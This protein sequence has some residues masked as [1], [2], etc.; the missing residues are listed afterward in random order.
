MTSVT[1]LTL[2]FALL[3]ACDG[4]LLRNNLNTELR[5]THM[6]KRRTTTTTTTVQLQRTAVTKE[7]KRR[8]LH[9]VRQRHL[10]LH[11]LI[12]TN[13]GHLPEA[14]LHKIS[15]TGKRL[16]SFYGVV[17]IGE[18]T[19]HHHHHD[20]SYKLLFDTGSSELWVT[21][22]N[23]TAEYEERCA[24]HN[25]YGEKRSPSLREGRHG[26]GF[27]K[28]HA[29]LEIDYVSG[30]IEG[31]L[32]RDA[33]TIGGMRVLQQL[34]GVADVVDVALL[35]DVVWDG[36]LGLGFPDASVPGK[37]FFDNALDQGLLNRPMFG[38][39]LGEDG[40]RLTLGGVHAENVPVEYARQCQGFHGPEW[41][42]EILDIEI[43]HPGS[44]AKRTGIHAK[45]IIDTGSFLIY[46]PE[47]AFRKGA[48]LHLLS[49]TAAKGCVPEHDMPAISFIFAGTEGQGP[50][51]VTLH[52]RDY[53]LHF[54]QDECILGFGMLILV[55]CGQRST[56][57]R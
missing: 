28:D 38:I 27:L 9:M 4:H 47:A 8:F 39:A 52:P 34:I 53:M 2:L 55:L 26:A 35:D 31:L 48:P 57:Q 18:C 16:S 13:N 19:H 14:E 45:A 56:K 42:L 24:K 7:D 11:S 6:M 32:A 46:G 25:L 17:Q 37:P 23:C 22:E 29:R 44:A 50:A 3:F 10:R 30:K 40:G 15:M 41:C 33:V 5:R 49:V 1:L 20:C 54:G 43:S 36:I 21:G 51:R 12:E